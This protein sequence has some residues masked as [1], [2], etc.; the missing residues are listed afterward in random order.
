MA[1]HLVQCPTDLTWA[2]CETGLR[3][4]GGLV[5]EHHRDIVLDRIDASTLTALQASP[6]GD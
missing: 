1:G 6:I 4:D 3:L 5:N 2:V